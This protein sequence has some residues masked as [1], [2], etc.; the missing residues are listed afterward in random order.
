MKYI[1]SGDKWQQNAR[2]F[3]EP[4]SLTASMNPT[5]GKVLLTEQVSTC[6]GVIYSTNK[7]LGSVGFIRSA[8]GNIDLEAR[9]RRF[10][11]AAGCQTA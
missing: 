10:Q 8:L 6:I 7:T 9:A 5:P 2:R 3:T 1:E 4:G 11:C